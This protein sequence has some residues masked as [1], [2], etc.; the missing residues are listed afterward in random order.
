MIITKTEQV[1]ESLKDFI[2]RVADGCTLYELSKHSRWD[3]SYLSRI[4]NNLQT[5]TAGTLEEMKVIAQSIRKER[6]KKTKQS[7]KNIEEKNR[8]AKLK[9]LRAL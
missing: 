9:R 3:Q 1:K 6:A 5:V 7:L 8:R 2:A 4:N